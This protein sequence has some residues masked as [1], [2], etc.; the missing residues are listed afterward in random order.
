[1]G[2]NVSR[3]RPFGRSG[4]RSGGFLARPGIL[5]DTLAM[6]SGQAIVT[7]LG[8]VQGAIL[9]RSLSV[10]TMGRYQLVLSYV[11]IGQLCGLPG[12]NVAVNKGAMKGH[13]RVFLRVLRLSAA[14][15]L[16]GAVLLF[17][18]GGGLSLLGYAGD[19]GRTL[20]IVSAF[21]PF[22]GL[23]KYDSLLIGKR[24]FVISRAINVGS[25]AL[26]VVAVG[27]VAWTTRGF[28]PT[29]A[30]SF[31]V[32]AVTTAAG[33]YIGWRQMSPSQ[34][35][36]ETEG[37]YLA[38]GWQQTWL[39][40]TG[41]IVG[42]LD[43]LLLGSIDPAMLALYYV[44]ALIPTKVKDNSKVLFTIIT[45]HWGRLSKDENLRLIR[46]HAALILGMGAALS[47]LIW[48]AAPL[49]IRLLYGKSYAA[50]IPIARFLCLPLA[51]G[52]FNIFVQNA[53]LFQDKGN[54]FT[55]QSYARQILYIGSL[56]AL[57][58]RFGYWGVITAGIL[59]EAF[60]FATS[61]LHFRKQ[62]RAV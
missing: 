58:P 20:M 29:L 46:R 3:G 11:A 12:M 37:L 44:G 42:Q 50:S 61:L 8:I 45:N 21:L 57:V 16:A 51:L 36:R 30:A 55:R 9:A 19:L 2:E 5:R 27:A 17:A 59:A 43:R 47:L 41:I 53:D 49:A 6:F 56:C 24:L 25:M 28:M 38:Q 54:F 23:E 35:D 40:L 1:M 10:E 26:G 14:W 13:D 4:L 31:C 60:A 33:L 52:F 34:E 15:A 18:A 32:R 7:V 39:A 48:L 22:H 62:L